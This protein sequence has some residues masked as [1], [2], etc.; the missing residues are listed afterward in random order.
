MCDK[1]GRR[2]FGTTSWAPHS[3]NAGDTASMSMRDRPT[4]RATDRH[5]ATAERTS[6][7]MSRAAAGVSRQN[8]AVSLTATSTSGALGRKPD[9]HFVL[10]HLRH[11]VEVIGG[12]ETPSGRGPQESVIAQMVI[13]MTGH[14]VEHEPAEQLGEILFDVTGCPVQVDGLGDLGVGRWLTVPLA[15]HRHGRREQTS[16]V[17]LSVEATREERVVRAGQHPKVDLRDVDPRVCSDAI[18]NVFPAAHVSAVVVRW[19]LRKPQR[20]CSIKEVRLGT[21]TTHRA[22]G[23]EKMP[24]CVTDGGRIDHDLGRRRSELPAPA[25][26]GPRAAGRNPDRRRGTENLLLARQSVARPCEAHR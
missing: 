23:G 25:P 8:G 5:S 17:P 24:Q 2:G 13:A 6:L 1:D 19:E 16:A 18:Q 21:G 22:A 12:S 4:S 15:E 14:D 10:R 7:T 20:A 26:E 3:S 9:S 11:R